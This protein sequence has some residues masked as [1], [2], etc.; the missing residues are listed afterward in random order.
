M[1]SKSDKV[2]KFKWLQSY[3]R[4]SFIEPKF[5]HNGGIWSSNSHTWRGGLVFS[6]GQREWP[7]RHQLFFIFWSHFFFFFFMGNEIDNFFKF[8]LQ[9][10]S[11]SSGINYS[12]IQL[13]KTS[14]KLTNTLNRTW[15]LVASNIAFFFLTPRLSDHSYSNLFSTIHNQT[16]PEKV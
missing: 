1:S 7:R 13:I 9:I 5:L 15:S 6:D 4:F 8:F 11:S 2:D 14:K 12:G 3:Y 16:P 10:P